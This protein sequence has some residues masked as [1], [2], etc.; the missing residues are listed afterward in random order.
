MNTRAFASSTRRTAVLLALVTGLSLTGAMPSF[1]QSAGGGGGGGGGSDGGA[2][3]SGG[4]GGNPALQCL[5]IHC[6]DFTSEP[7]DPGN[8][9][10]NGPW[11]DKFADKP[12]NPKL[13]PNPASPALA[14]V[15]SGCEAREV[16]SDLCRVD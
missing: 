6:L 13:E 12:K 7:K 9:F 14:A 15:M 2:G 11:C 4:G 5:G 1:A 3:G 8:P 16:P 10:C